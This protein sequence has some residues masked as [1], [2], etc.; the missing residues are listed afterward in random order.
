MNQTII[1]DFIVWQCILR[2]KNFRKFSGKPSEGTIASIIDNKNNYEDINLRSIIMEKN[3][4]NT[5]KMFEFMIKKTHDPEE[6]FLKAVKFFSSEYFEEPENF[7]GCFTSTFPQDS[8]ITKRLLKKK[9]FN[10]QFFESPTGFNFSVKVSKLKKND[11]KWT[12]TF[13]HNLFFN[14]SLNENIDILEFNPE[15]NGFKKIY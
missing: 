11:P 7:N 1:N 15:K 8:L 9:K 12:Y 14:S 2:Q 6:R 4:S 5:A 10:V 3:P 13:Y